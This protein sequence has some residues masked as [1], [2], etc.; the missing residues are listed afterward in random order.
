MT[1]QMPL[2][3]ALIEARENEGYIGNCDFSGETLSALDLSYLEFES[4]NFSNCRFME[5]D[6]SHT[7]FKQT[8]FTSCD[9]SSCK[10][11]GG[12]WQR[13]EL[14]LSKAEGAD[15]STCGFRWTHLEKDLLPY[16]CWAETFWE[17]CAIND[18]TMRE[19][20]LS[21]V[22]FKK[23]TLSNT[24][25]T[26]AEFFRTPLKD[27]DLSSCVID[28]ITVSDTHAELRGVQVNPLQAVELVRLLGVKVV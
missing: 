5:C 11:I 9:L 19:A 10:F 2:C 12:Y 22:K 20:F 6:F 21:E 17:N 7:T 8:T 23:T 26:R 13:V 3:E 1:D 14:Q 28:G 25:L 4:V 18:C 27:M 16:T 15:F 24:D